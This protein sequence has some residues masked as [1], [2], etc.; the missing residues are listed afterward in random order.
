[1]CEHSY[2]REYFCFSSFEK[3]QSWNNGLSK[4]SLLQTGVNVVQLVIEIVLVLGIHTETH[5]E[6]VVWHNRL[7]NLKANI[8][9]WIE[10]KRSTE[11]KD[12]SVECRWNKIG[13][14]I[15]NSFNSI[16]C[17]CLIEKLQSAREKKVIYEK[18]YKHTKRK[19]RTTSNRN[20]KQ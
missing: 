18:I 7:C 15:K 16:V 9:M 14:H 11:A 13:N 17:A 10:T 1:M 3:I 5:R 6:Q 20:T 4:T 8:Q 12:H 19:I 2:M